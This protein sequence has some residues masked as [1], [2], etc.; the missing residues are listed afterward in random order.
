MEEPKKEK[1]TRRFEDI[2]G[3]GKSDEGKNLKSDRNQEGKEDGEGKGDDNEDEKNKNKGK[4]T[5]KNKKVNGQ[6]EGSNL[7][8]KKGESDLDRNAKNSNNK[9]GEYNPNDPNNKGNILGIMGNPENNQERNADEN[10]YKTL[11]GSN[12]FLSVEGDVGRRFDSMRN[13]AIKNF[14]TK[15]GLNYEQYVKEKKKAMINKKK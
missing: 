4:K 2:W 3:D 9:D 7:D 5:K 12:I 15:R 1:K 13:E 8:E 11:E 6:K 14:R 10:N